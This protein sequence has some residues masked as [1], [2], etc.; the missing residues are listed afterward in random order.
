MA[1]QFQPRNPEEGRTMIHRSLFRD[2]RAYQERKL[3]AEVSAK[4]LAEQAAWWDT[5]SE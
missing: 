3:T 1:R 2:E 4:R 5:R